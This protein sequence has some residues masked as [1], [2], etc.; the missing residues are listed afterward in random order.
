M[1][2][3]TRKSFHISDLSKSLKYGTS[4]KLDYQEHG[5]PFLRI[6]DLDNKRFDPDSVLH[7]STEDASLQ[8]NARVR[9]G[10][11]LISRSGTLGLAV[12]ITPEFNNA[13]FGSYFIRVRPNQEVIN[14]EFLALYINSLAG[15]LQIQRLNTGGIQT[16]LTIP[17]IESIYVIAG[18]IKWQNSILKYVESSISARKE[19]KQLI[20]KAKR[21]VEEAV[22]ND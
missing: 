11:V 5:I 19:S 16:N 14:P 2:S 21:M 12:A 17:A 18:S 8:K 1:A 15:A 7:I 3:K 10:D 13:V 4:D 20:E 22:L 9:T 6:A